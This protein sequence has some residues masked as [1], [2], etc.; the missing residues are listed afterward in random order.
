M[1]EIIYMPLIAILNH[2]DYGLK[3]PF[4]SEI[5]FVNTTRFIDQKWCI[6]N[7][8]MPRDPE[9][10]PPRLRAYG[11]YSVFVTDP[12]C[13]LRDIV[14]T[15]GE[16]MMNENSFQVRNIIVKTFSR[17]IQGGG[18][19]AL[20]MAANTSELGKLIANQISPVLKDYGVGIPVLYIKNTSLP[21]AVET[22]PEKPT[23]MGLRVIWVNSLNLPRLR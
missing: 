6:K 8:I 12:L 16:F 10:D 22:A 19:S 17:V 5:Y 21:P 18:I 1:L 11:T 3:N 2:W 9:L 13:F 20:D 14:G 7:P 4:K 15:E 23:S